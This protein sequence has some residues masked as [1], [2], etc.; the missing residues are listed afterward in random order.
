MCFKK[1]KPSLVWV[2]MFA[3]GLVNVGLVRFIFNFLA[4]TPVSINII[5]RH[6]SDETNLVYSNSKI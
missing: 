5:G 6:L 3:L 1:N 4:V 2:R